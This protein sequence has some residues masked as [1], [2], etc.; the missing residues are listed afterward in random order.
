[1]TDYTRLQSRAV[2]NKILRNQ[3]APEV[4]VRK[5]AQKY[6]GAPAQV[7]HEK[8]EMAE[9]V[10]GHLPH[11]VHMQWRSQTFIFGGAKR[12]PK[13]RDHLGGS[14]GMHPRENFEI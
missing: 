4:R 14:G 11:V 5:T 3:A 2:F 10:E 8:V 1:M 9:R 6:S 7:L 13:A 12:S